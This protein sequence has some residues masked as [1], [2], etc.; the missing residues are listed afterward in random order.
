MDSSIILQLKDIIVPKFDERRALVQ[1]QRSP[2]V[3]RPQIGN[4]VEQRNHPF[5]PFFRTRRH[6]SL[7]QLFK[8]RFPLLI[9]PAGYIRRRLLS[10][11]L[12]SLFGQPGKHFSI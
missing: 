9:W 5:H 3:T 8:S 12:F 1:L 6:D 7:P 2:Q 10:V 4:G 11:A